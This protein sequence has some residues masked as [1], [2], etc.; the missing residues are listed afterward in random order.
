MKLGLSLGWRLTGVAEATESFFLNLSNPVNATILD[1]QGIGT[2]QRNPILASVTVSRTTGKAPLAVAFDATAT[3]SGHTTNPSHDLYYIWSFGDVAGETWTYGATTGLDKNA[4]YGPVAAHVFKSAGTFNWQLTI[5]DGRGNVATSDGTVT[6]SAWATADTIYIANGTTPAQGVNGVPADATERFNETTWAGVASRFAANKR[7]MLKRGDTWACG[8][9]TY[10]P[11]GCEVNSYGAGTFATVTSAGATQTPFGN[12]TGASDTRVCNIKHTGPGPSVADS[13]M[14][15][16]DSTAPV[17]TLLLGLESDG[18]TWGFLNAAP[19]IENIFIQDCYFHDYGDAGISNNIAIYI[20]A[21]YGIYVLG[22]SFD[23]APSH[24]VRFAGANK[25]VVDS[26]KF[27]RASMNNT[28]R[29]ALTVREFSNDGSPGTWNGLYTEDVIVSNLDIDCTTGGDSQ[30]TLHIQPQNTAYA[31][32]F[33]K[34]LVERNH[35]RS[36]NR[37]FH[38]Q[39][40]ETLTVRSNILV[41]SL[42]DADDAAW[43]GNDSAVGNPDPVGAQFYNNTIYSTGTGAFSAISLGATV[44]GCTV[45]NN[46]VYAPNAT[47]PTALLMAGTSTDTVNSNNSSNAQ[48]LSTR[49]WT[50]ASPVNPVDFTP[51]NYAVGAGLW[52]YRCQ[53]D[54]SNV[55]MNSPVEIGAINV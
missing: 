11:T 18:S 5:I 55:T 13:G 43:L 50:L 9:T 35:I 34:V 7:I 33:R 25:C 44:T 32:R 29:H 36:L 1:A 31:G 30:Y 22:S 27:R 40:G 46:L 4:A 42:T 17:N 48:A 21:G 23:R 47:T 49:P 12:N 16:S 52:D 8:A 15:A 6:V 54:F 41:T 39:V 24:L 37:A 10:L 28:G 2:I 53:K 14:V 51:V 20:H 38:T 26:C 45:R 19:T 3:V